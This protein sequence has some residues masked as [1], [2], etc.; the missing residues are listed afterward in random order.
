M[1]DPIANRGFAYRSRVAARDAGVT[2]VDFLV[3]RYPAFSREEWAGRAASGRVLV[4]DVAAT[5]DSPV[6]AGDTV[7]WLRPPWR[8][9][10]TPRTFAVLYRA[11]G[12]LAVAKPSGLPTIPGGGSFLENTLLALVRRHFPAASPLHRLGR[13]TSGVVLFATTA[14]SASELSREWRDREVVKVYRA[15]VAGRASAD[16]WNV[17]VP[18]GPVPHRVLGRVHAASPEGKPAHSEVTVLER[19]GETTLVEVRITTG[20]P[21]QIRIHL[22]ASGHP[23]VGDPLYANGG[24]PIVDTRALPGEGGYFLHAES[25]RFFDATAGQWLEIYCLPPPIL[26]ST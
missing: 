10:E 9:P 4:N 8:E 11:G 2:I 13:A 16:H 22:A 14:E 12:L 23:L 18:I 20:R 17:D 5:G 15:L 26:R 6:Q 21:H 24:L 7:T 25:L 19:R 1:S 3:R